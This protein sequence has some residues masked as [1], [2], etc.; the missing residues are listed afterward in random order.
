MDPKARAGFGLVA[1][2][3]AFRSSDDDED[4]SFLSEF[5]RVYSRLQRR[6]ILASGRGGSSVPVLLTRADVLI[7]W[8]LVLLDRFMLVS[9]L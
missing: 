3:E 6:N 2:S 5:W 1:A 4:V 7:G 9:V 8:E